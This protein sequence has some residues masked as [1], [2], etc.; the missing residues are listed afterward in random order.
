MPSA[1]RWAARPE[2]ILPISW[3]ALSCRLS[4]KACLDFRPIIRMH[5]LVGS[6]DI[7]LPAV[8]TEERRLPRERGV[9][10]PGIVPHRQMGRQRYPI[11]AAEAPSV[12][13][14]ER[15]VE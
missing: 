3:I 13:P 15:R 2:V 1:W 5:N 4:V 10:R 8:E 7:A 6:V 11:A 9:D 12:R 14:S